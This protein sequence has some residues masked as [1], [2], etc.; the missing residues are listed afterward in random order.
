MKQL[1][2]EIIQPVLEILSYCGTVLLGWLAKWLQSRKKE[3]RMKNQVNTL[4][5]SNNQLIN[6]I[7]SRTR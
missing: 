5:Q 7:K 2:P 6:K 1:P 4:M 3:E